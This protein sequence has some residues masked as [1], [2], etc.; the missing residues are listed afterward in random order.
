MEVVAVGVARLLVFGM[1]ELGWW[2]RITDHKRL[3]LF[4]FRQRQRF[5][6]PAANLVYSSVLTA[7]SFGSCC[8]LGFARAT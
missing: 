7:G 5:D 2:F 8:G 3:L 1:D 6:S 4:V